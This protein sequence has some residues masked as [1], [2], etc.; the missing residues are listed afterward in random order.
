MASPA[1][2]SLDSQLEYLLAILILN[3]VVICVDV[4]VECRPGPIDIGTLYIA[5]K[6]LNIRFTH[7]FSRLNA[8]PR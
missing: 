7:W 1:Q 3:I 8:E 6:V 2:Q 5:P 4:S